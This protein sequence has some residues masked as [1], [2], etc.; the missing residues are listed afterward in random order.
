MGAPPFLW[1]LAPARAGGLK[2][3]VWNRGLASKENQLMDRDYVLSHGPRL[4]ELICICICPQSALGSRRL[5]SLGL[6]TRR[7]PVACIQCLIVE[8]QQRLRRYGVLVR[9]TEYRERDPWIAMP[10][11]LARTVESLDSLGILGVLGVY[12]TYPYFL[13]STSEK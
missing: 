6:N 10:S 11:S 1:L 2:H 8:E 3:R 9:S 13:A 5:Q 7:Q 12:T 4:P